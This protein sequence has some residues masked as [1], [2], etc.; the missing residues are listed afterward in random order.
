MGELERRVTSMAQSIRDI[1]RRIRS[2]E[3]TKQITKA[4]KMVAVVKLRK[5]QDQ[6]EAARPYTEKMREV[7]SSIA[8][9][10]QGVKHPML[11]TRSV[12]KTG[13]LIITSDRG[14]AGGYNGNLLRLLQ[15][16]IED[17]HQSSEEY[18]I[19]V[20]GRKGLEFL[21]KRNFKVIGEVTGLG[22]S[23]IFADI[24]EI[25]EQ[26]VSFYA[27]G[28]FDELYLYYNEFINAVTQKPIEKRLLPLASEELKTAEHGKDTLKATYEYEPSGIQVLEKLL[29]HYAQ[30]LIYSALLEG[31]ASEF[32]A[33]MTAMDSA[34]DNATDIIAQL[35]LQFNRARQAAITQEIAEIVA[36]AAAL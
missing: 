29:P 23:P 19:F 1:K 32:A 24:Q 6:A 13:Y 33:R 34:T 20:I 14:L 3:N 11:V 16:T 10:T 7:I 28:K 2:V 26:A 12:R 5:A 36:G 17:R 30:M 31:K 27:E 21:R 25:S 18:E 22:D 4:M 35:T 15:K 8:K 9:A